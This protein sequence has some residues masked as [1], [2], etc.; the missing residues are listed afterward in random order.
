MNL[1]YDEFYPTPPALVYKMLDGLNLKLIDSVLEPSA[2]KGD[3]AD[4]VVKRLSDAQHS[5][6]EH[7]RDHVD[8]IEINTDLQGI[9]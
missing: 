6:D 7:M 2:G 1:N 9:L 4:I 8:C 3:I 5:Y